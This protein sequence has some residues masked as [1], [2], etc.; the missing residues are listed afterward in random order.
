MRRCQQCVGE[1]RGMTE[2]ATRLA[3]AASQPAPPGDCATG[4]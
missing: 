3:F 1:V 2:T 4:S